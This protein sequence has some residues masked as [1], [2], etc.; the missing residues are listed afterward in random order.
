MDVHTMFQEL[1]QVLWVLVS[2]C[3][4]ERRQQLEQLGIS[5][6]SAPESPSGHLDLTSVLRRLGELE[7]TSA[8][9]QL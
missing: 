4:E 7:I 2:F 3:L 5:I 6:E 9:M 8:M 1:V